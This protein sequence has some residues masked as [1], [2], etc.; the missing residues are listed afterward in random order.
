M[1][2]P[3]TPDEL[4]TTTRSVRKR[5]DFTR[6]VEPEVVRECLALA[7]QAP[8]GG[9]GQRW[10]WMVVTDPDKRQ[11][12][13]D[14]YRRGNDLYLQPATTPPTAPV[15]SPPDPEQAS[16]EQRERRFD[17]STEYLAEHIHE[18]PVM[19][20]PCYLARPEGKPVSRQAVLWGSILPA[21]WSF[22]LALR[23]RGLGTVWTTAH[24]EFERDA[25]EILAIPVERV[26]QVALFPVAYTL[27]TAFKPGY[28][29]PLDTVVR[30]NTW[31]D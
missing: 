7:I 14:C 5:L 31:A 28:R 10:R 1:L 25:A 27:G 16:R 23:S 21:A 30:W 22:M 17:A 4:L 3:L 2:L 8:N 9:N 19:V 20:I 13:G 24:L 15:Q 29:E 26:T 18:A 12:L 6:P 11:A